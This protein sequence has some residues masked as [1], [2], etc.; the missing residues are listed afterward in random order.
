MLAT[1]IKKVARLKNL[2]LGLFIPMMAVFI[3]SVIIL[4]QVIPTLLDRNIN[5]RDLTNLLTIMLLFI[6]ILM[7]SVTA[8]TFKNKIVSPLEKATDIANKIS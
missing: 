1:I 2:F 7:S 6:V 8:W 4:H 5:A 3:I